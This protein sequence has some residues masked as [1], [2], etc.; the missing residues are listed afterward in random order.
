MIDWTIKHQM[1]IHSI[2]E[3][4]SEQFNQLGYQDKWAL[5]I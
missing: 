3:T 1:E 5:S 2:I 4:I